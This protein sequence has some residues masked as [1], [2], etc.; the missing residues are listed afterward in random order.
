MRQKTRTRGSRKSHDLSVPD[1]ASGRDPHCVT[2]SA[3]DMDEVARFCDSVH[4]RLVGALSRAYGDRDLAEELA[5]EALSRVVERWERM[6]ALEDP[7]GYAIRIG[8]NLA[9]SWW[10]RRA[11][12]HR[13]HSRARQ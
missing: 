5:Q 7:E 10:R 9:R 8:F 2:T 13:A 12:E 11:A 4:S 3:S 6:R 1:R